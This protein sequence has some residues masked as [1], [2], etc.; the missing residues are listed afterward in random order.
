MKLYKTKMVIL[1]V[2]SCQEC[3]NRKAQA[4]KNGERFSSEIVCGVIERE[5]R[6]RYG[7]AVTTHPPIRDA[8]FYGGLY[9]PDCPLE[10]EKSGG[11]ATAR[12]NN[13]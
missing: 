2:P 13:G 10:D 7:E 9:L 12:T 1:R 4:Y 8:Q 6:N 3:P 11:A 5:G